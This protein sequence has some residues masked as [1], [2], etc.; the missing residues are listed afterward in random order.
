M[1]TVSDRFRVWTKRIGRGSTKVLLLHGGPGLGHTYLECFEDFLPPEG[2]ELYYYDQLGCGFSDIPKDNQLF[3]IERFAEEVEIVRSQLGLEK[4]ILYGHSW[5]CVLA[6]EYAMKHQ[7]HLSKLVLSNLPLNFSKVEGYGLKLRSALPKDVLDQ[8][9]ALEE[10]GRTTDPAYQNLM[11][12]HF[13]PRHM[14]RLNPTPEPLIRGLR[15]QNPR[16]MHAIQGTNEWK[17]TDPLKSWNR[18]ASLG[19]ISIPTLCIGSTHDMFD[20][21]QIKEDAQAFP[22]GQYAHCPNGSHLCMWDD[23]DAYFS[24]LLRFIKS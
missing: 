24:Q 5:G 7:L 11:Y 14:C 18:T 4:F 16:V 17:I 23:Q 20:P 6:V 2:I 12:R 1:I 10:A 13:Y 8:M 19:S 9:S 3:T 21:A 15:F 22:K